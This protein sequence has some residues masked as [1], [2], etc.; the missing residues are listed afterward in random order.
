MRPGVLDPSGDRGAVDAGLQVELPVIRKGVDQLAGARVDGVQHSSGCHQ[1]APVRAILAL[2]VVRSALARDSAEASSR[3][4][5]VDP[6]FLAGGRIER[7]QRALFRRDIGDVVHHQRAECITQF[8]ARLIAPGDLQLFDVARIHLF[9]RRIVRTVGTAEILAPPRAR[10][11]LESKRR[12][13]PRRRAQS[14][15]DGWKWLS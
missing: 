2:P 7:D 10:L 5:G 8:V 11:G 1:D 4:E 3:S 6:E 9:Q 14:G 15:D 12:A 13:G